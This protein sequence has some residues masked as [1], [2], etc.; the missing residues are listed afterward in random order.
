MEL[1]TLVNILD[2]LFWIIYMINVPRML[3]V[4]QLES[5]QG[6][7]MFRW[8]TSHPKVAFKKGGTQFLITGI[9][10]LLSGI[11][12]IALNH[13]RPE[14]NFYLI[15]FIRLV[16]VGVTYVITNSIFAVQDHKERKEAKKPLKF[17]GRAKRLMV[18]NF[19]ILVMLQFLFM[20]VIQESYSDEMKAVGNMRVPQVGQYQN[21]EDYEKALATYQILKMEYRQYDNQQ[22]LNIQPILFSF[23]IFTMPLNMIIANWFASP[24]ET[25][26]GNHY[27]NQ[28][29]RK[30]R[31]KEYENLIR[32]GITGSYGKTS[33]KFILKTILSEKY[34]V[35]ATPG[36]YNTTM[37]N[38]RII[39][40]ELKPEHQ[41]FISEMGAR[42]RFDIQEICQ[43]VE[44]QIGIITSIG[45][46]HLETFKKIENVAKTKGELLKGVTQDGAVFLPKDNSYCM[47]LYQKDTHKKY[48]YS[49]KKDG[50]DVY[51]KN[52]KVTKDGS[53]FTV[54][55]QKEE[56]L[57]QTKL[58]GEHNV[59]NIVGCVAIA[60]YLGLTNEE[61]QRGI[62]KIEPV[63]HRL[64]L[65][66]SA[67]GT[68]VIDDAFNSNPVGSKMALEV[69][70]QFEG[71]KIIITPGMVEL[72]TEEYKYN[73]EFG[74][75]MA[76]VV[77]V[78][79]L[80]GKKRSEPMVEGLKNKKFNQMNLYVV[81]DLNEAT[82]KLAKLT[83]A[84][85][86][87]LFEN[88]LPD[89]YNEK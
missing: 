63:E 60:K 18:Y 74:E 28:A 46:Q 27:I 70:K 4:M 52:I 82:Q 39:R 56:F 61:I 80:I 73:K 43:F 2:I 83:K 17:T 15:Y 51:A 45:P 31:K 34:N 8:I 57:C 32:I 1:N 14:N 72:G 12:A 76:D 26:I 59:Q 50:S 55:Y 64:Q 78:A 49:T 42:K 47:E 37:G 23:L 85:D 84:G 6:D 58:L 40:E 68:I 9:V 5:Y 86:V 16:L 36:S 3:H 24:M 44:P 38:V 65:I 7:G 87:I 33:T 89:N 81:K 75:Y 25:A 21:I 35:L 54:V 71:K 77:D 62:A 30:L 10:Y 69:L 19:F 66:P 48:L 53:T 11:V 79:I 29:R 41:V 20:G 88:D 13:Y 22:Y 67:N